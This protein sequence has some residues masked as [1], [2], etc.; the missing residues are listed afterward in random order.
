MLTDTILTPIILLFAHQ[1]LSSLNKKKKKEKTREKKLL[2]IFKNNQIHFA[3][4]TVL[5]D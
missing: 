5:A 3:N 2:G 1:I 4:V